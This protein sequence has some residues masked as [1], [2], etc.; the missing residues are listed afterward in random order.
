MCSTPFIC[1]NEC[2]SESAEMRCCAKAGK[3]CSSDS[4]CCFGLEC[5]G[6]NGHGQCVQTCSI[7]S[8][9]PRAGENQQ[10]ICKQSHC[11][12]VDECIGTSCSVGSCSGASCGN[13]IWGGAGANCPNG[14]VECA[15]DWKC[16][17]GKITGKC[18]GDEAVCRNNGDCAP[19]KM[20]GMKSICKQ[21]HCIEIF[22]V[23]GTS[24]S[25][26]GVAHKLAN[27]NGYVYC[28]FSDPHVWGGA[29]TFCPI[30]NAGCAGD[31]ICSS[32]RECGKLGAPCTVDGHCAD[33]F[34]CNQSINKCC[35][36]KGGYCDS[37][38]DCCSG[39][40][41]KN[42]YPYG[43]DPRYDRGHCEL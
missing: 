19:A 33:L 21:F 24:C 31:Y 42:K 11:I 26:G 4:D 15:G 37:C 38:S 7:D 30:G 17:S 43:Y 16:G 13:H 28:S 27:G 9:C 12:M 8:D 35:V 20:I 5:N 34:A 29:G 10:S 41:C 23:I 18:G 36:S 32:G 40:H 39:L 1:A 2:C 14:D 3:S 22:K 25:S 6:M